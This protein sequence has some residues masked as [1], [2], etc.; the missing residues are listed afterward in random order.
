MS[1]LIICLCFLLLTFSCSK[2]QPKH[3]TSIITGASQLNKYLPLLRGEKVALLVNQTSMI[4]NTH[5]VDTLIS[6][7][8]KEGLGIKIDKVFAPEHGFRG[9]AGAG[10]Q[11]N[12]G[13]DTNTGL[14]IISLYGKNKKPTSEQLEGLDWV[15]FDI[16]DVG[17]RFYTYISTMHYVMQA[18]AEN[19]VKMMVLDRPNPNGMYVDGPVLDTE[20]ILRWNAPNPY[21]SW[22]DCRRTCSNDQWR[23]MVGQWDIM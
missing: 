23:K 18:C 15:V 7:N 12:N 17:T 5:L 8:D 14:P 20:T 13:V 1:R 6:L 22:I 2:A 11:V 21:C 16:Q 10:E 3:P 9:Q 19:G 4:G